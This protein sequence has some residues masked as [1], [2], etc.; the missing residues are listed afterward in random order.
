MGSA[1]LS[2]KR[3]R[4]AELARTTAETS[5]PPCASRQASHGRRPLRQRERN[6]PVKNRMRETC[7]SGSVRGGDGDIPT[8][9]ACG[10]AQRRERGLEGALVGE[11]GER[12]GAKD[13]WVIPT[14]RLEMTEPRTTSPTSA[15]VSS[16]IEHGP[17]PEEGTT[18]FMDYARSSRAGGGRERGPAD[19]RR[20]THR[21]REP[22]DPCGDRAP[23]PRDYL[24]GLCQSNGRSSALGAASA[25]PSGD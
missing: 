12:A 13:D 25:D 5:S 23:L 14:D 16:L 19:R 4:I 6:S 15:H 7:T 17:Q 10:A 1:N 21:L 9:S 18:M 2:T 11:R 24:D 8:Y 3:Q 20:P 22:A